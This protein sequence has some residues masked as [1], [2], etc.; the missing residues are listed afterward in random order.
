MS[1][2]LHLL[3]SREGFK[4]NTSTEVSS[5]IKTKTKFSDHDSLKM[6]QL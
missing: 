3:T 2:A 4:F 5:L 1:L 6:Q